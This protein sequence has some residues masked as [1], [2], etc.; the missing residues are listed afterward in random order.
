LN[1]IGNLLRYS[2]RQ[3]AA[4]RDGFVRGYRA[5]GGILPEDWFRVARLQDLINLCIFLN[6]T[7]DDP[8]I[9]RDVVPLVQ[10]TV[11]LFST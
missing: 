1:D 5:G 9:T 7:T 3:P 6:P 11:E 8:A 4:Y 10:A 2:E